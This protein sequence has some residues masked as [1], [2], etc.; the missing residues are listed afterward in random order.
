[1]KKMIRLLYLWV[2][3]FVQPGDTNQS[4]HPTLITLRTLVHESYMEICALHCFVFFLCCNL[5]QTRQ[6]VSTQL[7]F[8]W[9]GS[10]GGAL[11][12]GLV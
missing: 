1:M 11:T 6:S 5:D 7:S 2:N 3:I 10:G 4:L 12:V 9:T 8:I